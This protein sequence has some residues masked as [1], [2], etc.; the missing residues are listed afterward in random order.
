[1]FVDGL[2]VAICAPTKHAIEEM[3][4][5][6]EYVAEFISATKQALSTTKS[7][8]TASSRAVGEALVARWKKKGIL[9]HYLSRVK[10]LGMGL[11]AGVRRNATV[12]RTRLTNFMTRVTRCRRLRRVGVNTARLR[13][14]GMRASTYSNAIM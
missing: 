2:V 13:R 7:N 12:M 8:V 4:G 10:A 9:I 5:F 11:G 3:G 1:M 14:T 6:I